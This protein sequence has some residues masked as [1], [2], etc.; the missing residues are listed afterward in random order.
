MTPRLFQPADQCTAEDL[1]AIADLVVSDPTA[2]WDLAGSREHIEALCRRYQALREMVDD[3]T[4]RD[5]NHE[6]ARERLGKLASEALDK[7]EASERT[8]SA[9]ERSLAATTNDLDSARTEIRALTTTLDAERN[10]RQGE[11]LAAEAD[12]ERADEAET[13]A[14]LFETVARTMWAILARRVKSDPLTLAEVVRAVDGR[15]ARALARE[16]A[17]SAAL[18]RQNESMAMLLDGQRE[19]REANDRIQSALAGACDAVTGKP[20][21]Q[22]NLELGVELAANPDVGPLHHAR[23]QRDHQEDTTP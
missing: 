21:E 7:A 1:D 6:Q 11:V 9:F 3:L 13:A 10:E 23:D 19:T 2:S 20:I 22:V 15:L 14:E 18:G 5:R 8:A 17:I 12:R 4:V 16:R